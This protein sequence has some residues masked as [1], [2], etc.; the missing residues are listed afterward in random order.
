MLHL[1]LG[2]EPFAW[3]VIALHMAMDGF[4]DCGLGLFRFVFVV[5]HFGNVFGDGAPVVFGDE[6]VEF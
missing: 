5:S 1:R 2:T 4:L 6:T 3:T